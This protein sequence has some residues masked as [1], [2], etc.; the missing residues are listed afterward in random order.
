MLY[1]W[2]FYFGLFIKCCL[3]GESV[4]QLHENA[5]PLYILQRKHSS[6]LLH[7]LSELYTKALNNREDF[8]FLM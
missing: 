5:K 4:M 2:W 6:V 1:C 3:F 8:N 7:E